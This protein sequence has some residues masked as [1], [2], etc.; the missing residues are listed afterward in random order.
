MI[1]VIARAEALK[2]EALDPLGGPELSGVSG[3]LRARG[4]R[5]EKPA[6]L[7]VGQLLRATRTWLAL[8]PGRPR[9]P[10]SLE[11]L[12][13]GSAADAE[14]TGDGSLRDALAAKG[15][16]LKA[17]VFVGG[18]ISSRDHDG[19]LPHEASCVKSIMRQSVTASST[20]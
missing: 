3:A 15:E 5:L 4:E 2:N 7:A 17:S 11:P 18:G 9:L 8:Q 19:R 6:A 20:R 12:A 1:D 13:Y 10:H 16:S 14:L